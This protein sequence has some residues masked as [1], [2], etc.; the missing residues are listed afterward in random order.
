M[1]IKTRK[2]I[3]KAQFLNE[4]KHEID[5]LKKHATKAELSRLNFRTFDPNF[6]TD[7]IYGQMTGTCAS[8]RAKQLMDKSC[9]RIFDTSSIGSDSLDDISNF[10]SLKKYI[11]GKYTDISWREATAFSKSI[12]NEFGRDYDYL[13]ALEG[14]IQT[15]G[16]KNKE[17]LEYL[18]GERETLKL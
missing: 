18:K 7:C 8:R 1:K 6:A 4:V 11:N 12:G 17:I 13:S 15:K 5:S 14:Y 9:V 10:N 16:A 3:T 2:A